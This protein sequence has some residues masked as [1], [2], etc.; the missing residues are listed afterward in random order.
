MQILEWIE[1]ALN[2]LQ[3]TLNATL[4]TREKND[5]SKVIYACDWNHQP[6]DTSEHQRKTT[7]WKTDFLFS[8]L[9]SQVMTTEF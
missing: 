2:P 7:T 4:S 6:S 5:Y 3:P 8:V 1:W 9:A